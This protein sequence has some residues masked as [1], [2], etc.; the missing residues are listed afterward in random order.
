MGRTGEEMCPLVWKEPVIDDDPFDEDDPVEPTYQVG[1]TY[2][3]RTC[4][5][6]SKDFYASS[7]ARRI[8][9]CKVCKIKKRR[10]RVK[11]HLSKLREKAIQ[12]L[13]PSWLQGSSVRLQG[14]E[15]SD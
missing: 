15:Y 3:C 6:Y 7:V 4:N 9:Q 10:E 5:V 8:R 14:E 1:E 2:W 11:S 13:Q 12:K